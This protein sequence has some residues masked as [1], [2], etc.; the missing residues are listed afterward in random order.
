MVYE[1]LLLVG[2]VFP[3]PH[4]DRDPRF[5]GWK[6]YEK[7]CTELFRVSQ[8]LK[9]ES[10]VIFYSKNHFV[11][12]YSVVSWPG[13]CWY[14]SRGERN[15]IRSIGVAFDMR[16]LGEADYNADSWNTLSRMEYSYLH[17]RPTGT[18]TAFDELTPSQR[19]EYIQ[20]MQLEHQ[21]SAWADVLG[22]LGNFGLEFLEIDLTRCFCPLGCH[23]MVGE[24]IG[25]FHGCRT[26]PSKVIQFVGLRSLAEKERIWQS[27]SKMTGPWKSEVRFVKLTRCYDGVTGEK[28]L[29]EEDAASFEAPKQRVACALKGQS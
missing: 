11:L 3:S 5:L 25:S 19:R 18:V 21:E 6:S 1:R 15:G 23:R 9:A 29:V 14:G 27:L 22:I 7:P 2:K 28:Y 10:E 20:D 26:G 8:R 24:V 17:C 12:P 4:D 13:S 16:D